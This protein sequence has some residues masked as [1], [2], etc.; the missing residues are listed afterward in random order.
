MTKERDVV[1]LDTASYHTRQVMEDIMH[2]DCIEKREVLERL[3]KL[4]MKLDGTT[5][6][7]E[8]MCLVENFIYNLQNECNRG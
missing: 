8:L 5:T 4:E 7:D 1:L 2:K 3:E 6:R